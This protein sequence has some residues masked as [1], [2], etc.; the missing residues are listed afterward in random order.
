[1]TTETLYLLTLNHEV[2]WR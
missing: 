2:C 1:M